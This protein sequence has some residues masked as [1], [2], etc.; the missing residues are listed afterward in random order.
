MKTV[1]YTC[2]NL[3]Y[4][5]IFS[6]VARTPGVE[7][8]LFTDRRPPFVRG[9]RWAPPPPQTRGLPDTLVNRFCKFFPH[10]IFPD[11]ERSVYVDANTLI[12]S[13][14]TP[15]LAEFEASGAEIG[16][17]PHKQRGG[18]AEELDYGIEVG[19]IPPGDV[20]K[21]RAQLAFYAEEGL[22]EGHVFTENAILFRRHGSERLAAAM[23]LWWEQLERFTRRDQLS[24]PY[25]L[26]KTGIPTHVWDWNYKFENPYFHRYLHRRNAL[27]DFNVFCKN[28]TFYGPV[29]AAV[30]GAALKLYHGLAGGGPRKVTKDAPEP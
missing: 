19:R 9:W 14:L 30:F 1:L 20:E 18:I 28:R 23:D 7:F 26:F 6:P 17:F 24:L 12:L 25:V 11:A 5:Q 10:R 3:A 13:D 15:L 16:L 8:V 4:D 2:S 29:N 27:Q 21:G 22:P